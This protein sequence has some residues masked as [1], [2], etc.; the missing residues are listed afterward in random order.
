MVYRPPAIVRVEG[1]QYS[2]NYTWSPQRYLVQGN[3]GRTTRDSIVIR[4]TLWIKTD[5]LLR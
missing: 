1:L 2:T 5:P 4:S 3:E